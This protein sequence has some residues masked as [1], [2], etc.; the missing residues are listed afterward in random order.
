MVHKE[1]QKAFVASDLKQNELARLLGVDRSAVNKQLIGKSNLTLRSIADF[2]WALDCQIT[3]EMCSTAKGAWGNE[4]P[5]IVRNQTESSTPSIS[6]THSDVVD[7][8]TTSAPND[9]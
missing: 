8:N 1:I 7:T 3:F 5:I 4:Q 6:M 2:A 9:A